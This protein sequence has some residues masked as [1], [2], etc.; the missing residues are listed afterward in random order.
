M[1]PIRSRKS[2]QKPKKVGRRRRRSSLYGTVEQQHLVLHSTIAVRTSKQSSYGWLYGHDEVITV[3]T[4]LSSLCSSP[5]DIKLES[6]LF[7]FDVH[8]HP[9]SHQAT[10]TTNTRITP[11]ASQDVFLYG[12][13]NDKN[14]K[15]SDRFTCKSS[16]VTNS[17]VARDNFVVG[18]C[19]SDNERFSPTKFRDVQ[20]MRCFPGMVSRISSE[21]NVISLKKR[22]RPTEPSER[23]WLNNSHASATIITVKCFFT[24]CDSTGWVSPDTFREA[25]RRTFQIFWRADVQLHLRGKRQSVTVSSVHHPSTASPMTPSGEFE[26][27]DLGFEAPSS[28]GP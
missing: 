19:L 16:G 13:P 6:I 5:Q 21:P 27:L 1:A 18:L 9:E 11:L 26:M 23:E 12:D 7:S 15:L 8:M 22:W 10:T 25:T 14:L 24:N 2:I 17:E 28:A 4:I 20:E 3:D